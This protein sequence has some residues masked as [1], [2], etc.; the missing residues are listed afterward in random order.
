[1]TLASAGIDKNLATTEGLDVYRSIS[2]RGVD[3]Y[4]FGE[5]VDVYRS[6]SALLPER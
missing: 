3:V 6:N 2:P 4:L 1:M 5:G